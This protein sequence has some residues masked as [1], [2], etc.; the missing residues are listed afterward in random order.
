MHFQ[1]INEDHLQYFRSV[2]GEQNV[3]TDEEALLHYGHDE[4]EDLEFPPEVVLKPASAIE[5]SSLVAFCNQNN[6][7]ITTRG[8]GTGLSG[9][10]L[11]VFGGVVLS[12][13]RLNKIIFIY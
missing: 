2:I 11:P 5:I 6:I 7:C 13:E 3:L 9:G 10:A 4:T 12:T 1:Q 8:G